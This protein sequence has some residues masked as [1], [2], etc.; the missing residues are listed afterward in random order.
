MDAQSN[1]ASKMSI[2]HKMQNQKAKMDVRRQLEKTIEQFCF[3]MKLKADERADTL[4][5]IA[6]ELE[7]RDK[8]ARTL[9]F[10]SPA[11]VLTDADIRNMVAEYLSA[12]SQEMDEFAAELNNLS[13]AA[14]DE[15][16]M[17]DEGN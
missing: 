1:Q 3:R 2:I 7:E 12:F 16:A 11:T 15:L 4:Q 17:L 8:L 13:K 5:F 9:A 6:D 10:N 14:K